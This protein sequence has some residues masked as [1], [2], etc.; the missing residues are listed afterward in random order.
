MGMVNETSGTATQRDGE[1]ASRGM[2]AIVFESATLFI[3]I[4]TTVFGNAFLC[5]VIRKNRRL[6]SFVFVFVLSQAASDMLMAILVMPFTA[7]TLITGS[8]IAGT[9]ICN[10]QGMLILTFSWTSLHTMAFIAVNRF[11]RVVKPHQHRRLFT[12]CS[13]TAMVV[14]IW[15]LAML[16]ALLPLA[17]DWGSFHF[18]SR[19]STCFVSIRDNRHLENTVYTAITLIL[20]IILPTISI[21]YSYWKVFQVVKHHQGAVNP[22]SNGSVRLN[23]EEIKV[24]RILFVSM[25]AFAV[26]WV[27]VIITE[28]LDTALGDLPRAAHLAYI[29]LGFISCATSPLIYITMHRQFRSELYRLFRFNRPRILVQPINNS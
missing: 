25:I 4:I 12:K 23:V 6:H 24:I 20:Y 3:V 27:P 11:F 8:W 18:H 7:L 28:V 5:H 13:V 9:F 17:L 26:C 14:F 21:S 16:W 15:L 19:K 22:M 2:T 29:Y 10:A 1:L